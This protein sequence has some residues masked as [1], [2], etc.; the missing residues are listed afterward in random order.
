MYPVTY[1]YSSVQNN[2][3]SNEII[4]APHLF[5]KLT[6]FHRLVL[7]Y[8]SIFL[9]VAAL[10]TYTIY[11]LYRLNNITHLI[12][13]VDTAAINDVKKIRDSLLSQ[14]RS[15]N[16]YLLT[17]DK[18]FYKQF[19]VARQEFIRHLSSISYDANS[20]QEA[21]INRIKELHSG[22]LFLFEKEA[23]YL[24][25]GKDYSGLSY[26]DTKQEYVNGT[27]DHLKELNRHVQSNIDRKM[28]ALE[29]TGKRATEM[30]LVMT[31]TTLLVGLFISLVITQ[32]I[33]K[34]LSLLKKRTREIAQKG[35][36]DGYLNLSS[37]P[38]VKDLASSFNF[39]CAKLK[40]LDQ[41]KADF[42]SHISHD[43]R[44]PLTSIREGTTLLL[45]G[46]GG[47]I[48]DKQKRLLTIIVEE[49]NR[50]IRSVNSLLDL[51]KM[52]AGIMPEDFE[53]T[54]IAPLINQVIFEIE[55]IVEG[56]NIE[57]AGKIADTLPKVNVSR[58]RIL[59]VLRNL[60]GNAVKFTPERGT[61]GVNAYASDHEIIVSVV[62]TGPGIP[63]KK[64]F[65]IFDKFYQASTKDRKE[66]GGTGLGL[67]I[68]KNIINAHGGKIWAETKLNQ[69][70]IFTFTLP[71]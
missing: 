9:L 30:A 3:I 36:F 48:T 4:A 66:T 11:Q 14:V 43:L 67:C 20:D 54:N 12:L 52:E 23:Q 44:T 51:S 40:K 1:K 57:V 53:K 5:M 35:V 6:I 21:L 50:L 38:E 33:N 22:Y 42:F 19:Q 49:S 56:K 65:S 10:S 15:E 55:P 70:S 24:N 7:G 68:A 18:S 8:L 46:V 25:E 61:I 26:K 45:E 2:L 17:R 47:T 59:Q 28:R 39:M 64:L 32:S 71:V 37:P 63:E 60:L 62:D 29:A 58:E 31:V 34:P 27:I 13:H 41:M 69:G 16:K